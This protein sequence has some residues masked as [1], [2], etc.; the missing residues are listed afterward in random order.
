MDKMS[1]LVPVTYE[2]PFA[3]WNS[4]YK[5]SETEGLS[6]W[7]SK[8]TATLFYGEGDLTALG[9]SIAGEVA[10]G[11]GSYQNNVISET[12]E[13]NPYANILDMPSP[14]L[15]KLQASYNSTNAI[16]YLKYCRNLAE[17]KI[18]SDTI[19]QIPHPAIDLSMEPFP[20]DGFVWQRYPINYSSA[21]SPQLKNF[22]YKVIRD[23]CN[24]WDVTINKK[25]FLE[26]EI[27][28]PVDFPKVIFMDGFFLETDTNRDAYA[29]SIMINQL[30]KRGFSLIFL[31]TCKHSI[32]IF[33][34]VY[35]TRLWRNTRCGPRNLC[36]RTKKL[37][38]TILQEEWVHIRSQENKIKWEIVTGKYP[39]WIRELVMERIEAQVPVYEILTKLNNMGFNISLPM[40]RKKIHEW[41]F[42]I[43][44]KH[45]HYKKRLTSTEGNQSNLYCDSG[46]PNPPSC[47]ETETL[48]PLPVS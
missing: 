29:L 45:T 43:Y 36:Y 30:R 20:A 33:D 22:C 4:S 3:T 6:P 5:Y 27:M 13:T 21:L 42:R 26:E 41:G 17:S 7:F 25:S 47:E 10:F 9:L 37:N 2:P 24:P 35:E 28:K 8:E 23:N 34:T 18:F 31:G 39:S 19:Q 32:K 38:G 1:N 12:S 16:M 44:K 14:P 11:K 46:Q 40:L 15:N 48:P